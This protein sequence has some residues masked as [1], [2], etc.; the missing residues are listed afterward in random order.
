M[1]V[2][3]LS[4]RHIARRDDFARV[5]QLLG[6]LDFIPAD[7]FRVQRCLDSVRLQPPAVADRVDAILAAGGRALSSMRQMA[8]LRVLAGFA[9]SLPQRV[10]QST[11]QQL[12][13]LQ[14]ELA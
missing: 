1:R 8:A 2:F 6:Q 13:R 11:F 9:G 10:S 5:A 14:S 3:L 7:Q 4:L 12:N